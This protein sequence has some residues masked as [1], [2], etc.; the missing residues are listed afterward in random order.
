MLAVILGNV[1][2][3]LE[4]VDPTQPIYTDLTEIRKAASRS[5][6]LTRQLL[7]FA[8]KQTIALRV[9]D[10]SEAVAGMLKMLVRLIGEN[11]HL[12]WHPGVNLWPVEVDTS[13]ID[14]ILTNLCINARDAVGGIGKITVETANRTLDDDYCA[15]HTGFLPGDYVQLTVSD[16]GHGMDKETLSHIFEP[17]FTTKGTGEG[18]GLGLAT[19]YGAVKQN[20]GFINVYSEPDTGTTFKIYLPRHKGSAGPVA[21]GLARPPVRGKETILLVEDEPSM[22]TMITRML[23]RQGYAVIPANTPSEAIRLAGE[24]VDSIHLLMTDVVMPEMNGR[25]L[26]NNLISLYPGLKRLFMSGSTANV[27]AHNGVL[28]QGVHFIQKPFSIEDLSAKIRA[29]LDSE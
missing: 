18:T 20:N 16:D 7:A 21:E 6:E 24:N 3:A 29:V 10:L 8:R 22:L 26:A 23:T 25:D 28:D 27:I 11:V 4:Q 13:Q 19:V 17:F 12:N 2:M 9:V 14:Q 1:Q 5:A 15:V